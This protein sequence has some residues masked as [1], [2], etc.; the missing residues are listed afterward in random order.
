MDRLPF[1]HIGLACGAGRPLI[2]FESFALSSEGLGVRSE[3][4]W[5]GA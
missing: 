4:W 2:T 1:R 3:E 5:C